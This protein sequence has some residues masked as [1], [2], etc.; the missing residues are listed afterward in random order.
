MNIGDILYLIFNIA[1]GLSSLIGLAVSLYINKRTIKISKSIEQARI[2]EDFNINHDKF[3]DDLRV[4]GLNAFR[5]DFPN[6]DNL[7]DFEYLL[8]T[9]QKRY[10]DILTEPESSEITL[11]LELCNDE[12]SDATKCISLLNRITSKPKIRGNIS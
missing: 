2:S 5:K 12:N 1:A 3:M 11:L 7:Q 4:S 8:L 10:C 6:P 9:Y